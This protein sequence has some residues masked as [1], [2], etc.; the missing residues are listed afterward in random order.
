VTTKAATTTWLDGTAPETLATT[1]PGVR[2]AFYS[3][4]REHLT[5]ADRKAAA[6]LAGNGLVLS[7]LVVLS[8]PITRALTDPDDRVRAATTVMLAVLVCLL[9]ISGFLAFRGLSL[10]PP[11]L[12]GN[13]AWW[14]TAAA[15]PLAEYVARMKAMTYR[16]ATRDMLHFN[17]AV[18]VR[19]AEKFRRVN[20]AVGLFKYAMLLWI[21]V[22]A[23][24]AYAGR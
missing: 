14:G 18:A 2:L 15:A 1:P 7:V 11:P 3:P 5:L 4:V 8:Q 22:L 19:A 16:S 13:L 9:L 20:A 23:L 10:N 6:L 17:H 21:A 24:A 12:P